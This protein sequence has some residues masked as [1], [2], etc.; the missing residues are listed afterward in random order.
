YTDI[1]FARSQDGGSTWQ[2]GA[3]GSPWGNTFFELAADPAVPGRVWAAASDQHDIPHWTQQEGATP[4]LGGGV[5][6]SLD[7][8]KT[9]KAAGTGLPNSAVVSVILDPKSPPDRRRLWASLW[10]R[11]VYR[12]DDGG[13][14]WVDKST[15]LGYPGNLN[16]YRLQLSAD[17]LL[18]CSVAMRRVNGNHYPVPGG[19]WRSRDGGD[20]WECATD[21][22]KPSGMIDFALDPRDTRTMYLCQMST[23]AGE[24]G[25]AYK[26]VDGGQ[27]WRKLPLKVRT[28]EPYVHAFTPI[29]HPRDPNV[30]F[31]TTEGEGIWISRDAGATWQEFRA[32]PFMTAH[33]IT[34][35]PV[36]SHIIYITTFGG[37]VWKVTLG[38][39]GEAAV[40]RR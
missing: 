26:T 37:G 11:G 36:D 40:V 38:Q 3:K 14:T 39:S 21:S 8:M 5:V 16:S 20:T 23:P 17:G 22:L 25:G 28:D 2:W 19:L 35:D 7:G 9:W 33:R 34:F 31:V 18:Y 13:L 1:G 15:G 6:V 32:I 4:G 27:N 10:S 30:V 12:S 29:L 24:L